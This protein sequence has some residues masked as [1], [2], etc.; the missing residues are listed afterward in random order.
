MSSLA[1]MSLGIPHGRAAC[2]NRS[3]CTQTEVEDGEPGVDVPMVRVD[4]A[5]D[6][7]PHGLDLADIQPVFR[8]VCERA[9]QYHAHAEKRSGA[10]RCSAW[11]GLEGEESSTDQSNG[12][13]LE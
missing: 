3:I 8:W 11:I 5:Y 9:V 2:A 12:T 7:D 13:K 10:C 1:R 4:A 6:V